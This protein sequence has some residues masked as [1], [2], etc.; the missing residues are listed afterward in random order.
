MIYSSGVSIA[1]FEQVN[2]SW[3]STHS[4]GHGTTSNKKKIQCFEAFDTQFYN[5]IKQLKPQSNQAMN[6]ENLLTKRVS[7]NKNYMS[8]QNL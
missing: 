4:S 6:F 7:N 1:P 5:E 3:V 2:I 8:V